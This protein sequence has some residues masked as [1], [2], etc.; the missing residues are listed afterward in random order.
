MELAE[1]FEGEGDKI[2]AKEQYQC[3]LEELDEDDPDEK[4][5]IEE[6]KSLINH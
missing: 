5:K 3:A 1:Y 2:K 6:L 4:E